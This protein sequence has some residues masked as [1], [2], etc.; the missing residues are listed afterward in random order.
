VLVHDRRSGVDA[1]DP[2]GGDLV[3]GD[4]YVGLS[5]GPGRP[6]DRHLDDHRIHRPSLAMFR[7]DD[8]GRTRGFGEEN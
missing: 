2:V 7:D 4:G 5:V 8:G 1:G 6:V 3:G